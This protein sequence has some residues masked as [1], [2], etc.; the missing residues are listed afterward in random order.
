[1]WLYISPH[2]PDHPPKTEHKWVSC[3]VTK[4]EIHFCQKSWFHSW[5]LVR[6]SYLKDWR[7]GV[8]FTLYGVSLFVPVFPEKAVPVNCR[9]C[10][11]LTWTNTQFSIFLFA[12]VLS[13]LCNMSVD[14][15]FPGLISD[16]SAGA[17]LHYR[18]ITCMKRISLPS[19]CPH[20][21]CMMGYWRRAR[22]HS[23]VSHDWIWAA[24]AGASV[25]C[26]GNSVKW[27]KW[28]V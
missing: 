25:E 14:I 2:V 19:V 24:H 12:A 9:I 6:F 7:S 20:L 17:L 10:V 4:Q 16:N 8:V 23:T 21:W 26:D 22:V 3:K 18:T 1:M 28:P 11:D 27:I 15:I 13:F 5:L